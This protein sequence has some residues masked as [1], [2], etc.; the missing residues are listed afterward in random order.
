M[1]ITIYKYIY[2]LFVLLFVIVNE[3]CKP[4]ERINYAIDIRIIQDGMYTG[5][6]KKRNEASVKVEIKNKRIV[7]L[8][9]KKFAATPFGKKA[10]DSIPQRIFQLQYHVITSL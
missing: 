1:R 10:K 3:S 5:Y 7:S 4:T 6:F 2:Q 8:T 9:L